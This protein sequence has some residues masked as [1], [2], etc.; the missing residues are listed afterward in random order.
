MSYTL[1]L[2][3][4]PA[5]G[6]CPQR[7]V[8]TVEG[9]QVVDTLYRD[10]GY[11]ER[12]IADRLPRLALDQA[13]PLVARVCGTCSHA[14][15]LAFCQAVEAL[16]T[17][18]VPPRAAMLRCAL[19]EI[20]RAASHLGAAAAIV[21]ALGL[22][23][24]ETKLYGLRV[25][26]RQAMHALSG[27]PALPDLCLPGGLRRNP[28]DDEQHAALSA[29]EQL[30][31][32]LFTLTDQLIERRDLLRRTADIGV[33]SRTV[34]EQFGLRGPLARA[35]G[36]PADLRI[37]APYAAYAQL[38]PRPVTQEGGDVY[39]RLMTLLLEALESQRQ[40]ERALQLAPGG[41]WEGAMPT[42]LVA[43]AASSAVEAPRGLLRYRIESDGRRLTG[44]Q[45]DAPKQIDRLIAR[46]LLNR[47]LLDNVP[48][49]LRSIDSCTAC[50]EG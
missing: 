24:L 21:A 17:I 41:A 9:E 11:N 46:T 5:L 19:A 22:T 26:V 32:G 8:L 18:E 31:R 14:H 43:G 4:F 35:A 50:A 25:S 40:A 2:G 49:I 6:R 37:D 47:A 16:L 23:T 7:L 39:A 44:V 29:L 3:P 13:L 15:T 12:G 48:L 36:L 45:L 42:S 10:D 38:D 33:L 27:R 34:A 30:H 1:A 28:T 20:E